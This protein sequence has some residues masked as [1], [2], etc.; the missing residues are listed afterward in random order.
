MRQ[1]LFLSFVLAISITLGGV[2]TLAKSTTGDT[3]LAAARA[4]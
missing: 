1:P 2:A 3:A 4:R